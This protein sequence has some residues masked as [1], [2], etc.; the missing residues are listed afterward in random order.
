[1]SNLSSARGSRHTA[2]NSHLHLVAVISV[3]TGAAVLAGAA[4]LLSYTGI[5]QI[6][7]AA[8]LSPSLAKLYPVLLDTALSI[9]CVAALALRGAPWWMRGYA[10]SAIM[11]LLAALA[12]A[13]AMHSAGISLPRRPTAAALAAIP[14]ALFLVGFGL[15]LSVFR[16]QQKMRA[17]AS[18][19]HQGA[20]TESVSERAVGKPA[21][22]RRDHKQALWDAGPHAAG[23]GVG[24]AAPQAASPS[25]GSGASEPRPTSASGGEHGHGTGH[26]HRRGDNPDVNN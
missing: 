14:W 20:E 26:W 22:V 24:R 18:A 2:Y 7:L 19:D 11:I 16:Y 10:A 8:G 23:I 21:V 12:V 3:I 13:E 6:A 15:G 1:M 4:F 5:H 17:S 9:A 25:Q